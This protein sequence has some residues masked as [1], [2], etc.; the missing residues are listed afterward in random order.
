MDEETEVGTAEDE[1][2]STAFSSKMSFCAP[3]SGKDQDA[4]YPGR[5]LLSH[6]VRAD[7][8]VCSL[9]AARQDGQD[10]QGTFEGQLYA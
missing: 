1:V 6:P 8:S 7:F 2:D 5:W 9:R 10:V 3:S 4:W